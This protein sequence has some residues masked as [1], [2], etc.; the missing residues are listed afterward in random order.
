[1]AKK[2]KSKPF[3][4]V[5]FDR[6]LDLTKQLSELKTQTYGKNPPIDINS[7]I[8]ETEKEIEVLMEDCK[9]VRFVKRNSI[10]V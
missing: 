7:R 5:A 3:Y 6:Y 4:L 1:M 2:E 10:A 9:N 8:I